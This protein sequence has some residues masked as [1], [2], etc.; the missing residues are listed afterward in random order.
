MMLHHKKI[1][2]YI[3][4]YLLLFI[5]V[6]S[7]GVG[8]AKVIAADTAF[9]SRNDILFYDPESCVAGGNG[10]SGALVGNDNLEKILR[11]YVGKGLTLAQAA[12][13]AGNY[14]RE[15]GF[16]PA[17][18]QGGEIAGDN[19]QPVNTVGFGIAQWTFT[20]RQSPLVAL[21]QSTN[22]KITDLSLQLDYTWQELTT[23]YKKGL[24]NLKASTTADNAAYVFHR[25]YEGSADTEAEV[26]Q[27]RGGDALVYQ[28][29]FLTIIPDGT[30]TTAVGG[31]TVCSG[32][33]T[34]SPFMNGFTTYNQEDPAWANNEYGPGGTIATSGCG[35]SAMAMIITNLTKN[36]VTPADTAAYGMANGTV[37]VSADGVAAGS[38][39]NIDSVIGANWGLKTTDVGLDVAKINQGLRDGGLVVIAGSG[40]APFTSGGHIIVIRAVTSTGKWMI[41]DSNGINGAENSQKEWDPGYILSMSDSGY[42]RLLTK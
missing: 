34:A 26:K 2:Q 35:P 3:K 41:G 7:F 9:F 13:I 5:I 36:P 23:L 12:G 17:V 31:S 29:Q 33:G 39:H 27:N 21:A 10:G 30:T 32:D 20:V 4:V 24:D 37:N 15:S 40:A 38:K 28:S 11:F 1:L 25:D 19:Y 22:R 42:A 14:G 8:S 18:I 16:N 6:S